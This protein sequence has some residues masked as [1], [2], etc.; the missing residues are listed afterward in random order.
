MLVV[1]E[2]QKQP[3]VSLTQASLVAAEQGGAGD[4]EGNDFWKHCSFHEHADG[5]APHAA[6][7]RPEHWSAH[8]LQVLAFLTAVPAAHLSPVQV[9]ESVEHA[10]PFREQYANF[11]QLLASEQLE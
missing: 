10:V 7:S 9:I 8:L 3:Y 2:T 1:Y 11:V 4:G 6:I 5:A